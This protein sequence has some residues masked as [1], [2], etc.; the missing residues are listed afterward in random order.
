MPLIWLKNYYRTSE[1]FFETANS[2]S[3]CETTTNECKCSATSEQCIGLDICSKEGVCE[4]K[5][6]NTYIKLVILFQQVFMSHI[7]SFFYH[8]IFSLVHTFAPPCYKTIKPVQK[9]ATRT[10]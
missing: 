2:A 3:Y 8:I 6:E 9:H 7:I 4:G 5:Y 1:R 10:G